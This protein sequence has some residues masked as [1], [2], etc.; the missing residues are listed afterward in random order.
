MQNIKR[1]LREFN[2]RPFKRWELYVLFAFPWVATGVIVVAGA[3]L[4][5]KVVSRESVSFCFRV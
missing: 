5:E 4:I 2:Q 3:T 1:K